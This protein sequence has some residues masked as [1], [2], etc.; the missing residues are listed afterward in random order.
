MRKQHYP[1]LD[2]SVF[3]RPKINNDINKVPPSDVYQNH[4][5]KAKADN[6][7]RLLIPLSNAIYCN[8]YT[9]NKCLSPY[10]LIFLMMLFT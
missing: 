3:Y 4:N 2:I 8:D 6:T 1:A 7:F 5:K 9:V 10:S